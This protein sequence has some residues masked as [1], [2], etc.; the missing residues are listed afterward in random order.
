MYT[1]CACVKFTFLHNFFPYKICVDPIVMYI[2]C[3]R[4]NIHNSAQFL[5]L[6]N[7]CR[8]HSHVYCMCLCKMHNSAQF[9]PL[10]NLSC[11][12]TNSISKLLL[13]K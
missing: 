5:P 11:L 1:V 3:A 2:V 13:V 12:S 9:L 10:E 8:H 7:M 4:V 6:G